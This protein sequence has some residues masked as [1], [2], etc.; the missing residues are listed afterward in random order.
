LTAKPGKIIAIDLNPYHMY[1]TRLKI[2]CAE[3]LPTYEMFFNF[4]GHAGQP[5]NLNNYYTYVQ[6]HLDE[7]TRRF[8]ESD[9][10]L[11]RTRGKTRIHYFTENFYRYAR[12]GYFLRFMHKLA[13]LGQFDVKHLLEA[14]TIEEQERIFDEKIAPFFDHW[15]VK[16]LGNTSFSVFSLGIPPQQCHAMRQDSQGK[17]VELYRERVKRL[18]CGFP[19]QDNYFAWQSFGLRYDYEGRQALPDYLK[20]ENYDV[21]KA[22]IHHVDTYITSLTDYLKQQP[23]NSLDRYVLLDSQDWMRPHIIEQLWYEIL[24]TGRPGARIIFRTAA[25]IS[26]IE[27]ALSPD[28][29]KHF[30]YAGDLSKELHLQDRSAI[31]GGFHI[32]LMK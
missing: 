29:R 27:D 6:A 14:K 15:L 7:T 18:V 13:R 5:E 23:D 26:P 16:K 21:V 1:L 22:N 24:R 12:S 32:Y 25:S 17:L 3:Y 4:F 9:T 31:Y 10:W 28:L 8:W 11:R 30:E 2:A 20:E 19:I